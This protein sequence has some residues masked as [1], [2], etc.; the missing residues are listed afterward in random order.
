M[1]LTS[2]NR[3]LLIKKILGLLMD[4]GLKNLTMDLVAS[5]L[6]MSKRTLYEIFGSKFDMI[7]QTLGYLFQKQR[8]KAEN[9]FNSAPNTMVALLEIFNQ[10]NLMLCSLTLDF[11]HDIDTLYPEIGRRFYKKKEE[12][13]KHWF[14][15]YQKGAEEG[16]FRQDVNPKVILK[17]FEYQLEALK[18]MESQLNKEF[19][20]EE[21]YRTIS[22]SMLRSIAT[23]HG[24][25]VLEDYMKNKTVK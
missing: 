10:W 13:R 2:E 4:K 8:D 25:E 22:I 21:I 12:D 17:M 7:D 24:L 18:R 1:E 9:I 3:N 20:L 23:V 16:L 11:F 6:S 15:I 14:P 5:E 19:T